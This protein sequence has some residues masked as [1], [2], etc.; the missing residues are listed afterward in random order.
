M[1]NKTLP[2]MEWVEID[3]V[4]PNPENPRTIKE[5]SIKKLMQSIEDLPEHL[6]NRFIVVDRFTGF[7]LGGNQ[8]WVAMKRL[9]HER[10]PVVYSDL[11]SDEEKKEFVIKDNMDSGQWDADELNR[12][13]TDFPLVEWDILQGKEEKRE[14][15][16][17]EVADKK[18]TY[19]NNEMKQI[20]IFLDGTAHKE[21][22]KKLEELK[23]K[24]FI[25]TNGGVLLLLLE[26]IK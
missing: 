13:F 3:K 19:D 15:D 2:K 20:S 6:E 5:R 16:T 23:D 22:T 7:I 21:V 10:I 18:E 1:D 14:K 24:N 26:N 9:G 4:R 17:S 8:R 11:L 25:D 12:S